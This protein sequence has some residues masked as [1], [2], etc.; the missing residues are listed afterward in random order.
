M[1]IIVTY[2]VVLRADYK[3]Y[4]PVTRLS[5]IMK[6][7]VK[8]RRML[9]KIEFHPPDDGPYVIRHIRFDPVGAREE[10]A[11]KRLDKEEYREKTARLK[12]LGYL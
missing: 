1:A 8:K 3:A 9:L 2:L 12:A 11:I 4:S 5:Q 10:V 6:Y 7:I